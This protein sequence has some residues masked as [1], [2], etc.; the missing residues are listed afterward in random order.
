MTEAGDERK[1]PHVEPPLEVP[2]LPPEEDVSTAK[3]R[4]QLDSDPEAVPNATD[5]ESDVHLDEETRSEG[6]LEDDV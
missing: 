2:D 3:A 6:R 4:E 1:N 5:P